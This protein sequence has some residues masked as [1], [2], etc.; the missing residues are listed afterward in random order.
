MEQG[1]PEA[2]VLAG[3]LHDTLEDTG[4]S[5]ESLRE[6]FGDR[7]V[8]LVLAVTE[9][10]KSLPWER[11]K[12][13]T[14]ARLR[15][16]SEE[17]LL[18]S[19]ADKL[20]N[21]QSIHRALLWQGESTWSRFNRPRSQQAWYYGRLAELFGRRIGEGVGTTLVEAFNSTVLQVFQLNSFEDIP[22]LA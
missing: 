16:A 6:S 10:D 19:L 13:E 18:L 14:L 21:I 22:S 1:A 2:L 3:F 8:D 9:R 17:V 15:H 12:K 5:G 7:V 4:V 11:R 20:D